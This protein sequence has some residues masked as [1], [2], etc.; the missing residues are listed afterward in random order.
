[1]KILIMLT[2]TTSLLV[3]CASEPQ[4]LS[5]SGSARASS[6]IP[7]HTQDGKT[8]DAGSG[9]QNAQTRNANAP[10]E[11]IAVGIAPDRENYVYKLMVNTDNPISEVEINVRLYDARAKMLD[12]STIT[13]QNIVNGTRQ[14][15]EKGKTYEAS[16]FLE[17]DSTRVE[18][19]VKH[20]Y[21]WD[22]SIWS[23]Q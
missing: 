18:A 6:L 10:V 3:A 11:V 1:M 12:E 13:W 5:T 20:V 19:E 16:H 17:P 2:V 8:E 22:G 23:A 4:K 7:V 15:T 21:F 9:S 14:P